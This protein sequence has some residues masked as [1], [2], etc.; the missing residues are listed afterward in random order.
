MQG[1]IAGDTHVAAN[2]RAD[3]SK[4]IK[5]SAMRNGFDR[6]TYVCGQC[7]GLACNGRGKSIKQTDVFDEWDAPFV[8]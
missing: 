8:V 7:I 5:V 6:E 3:R 1:E 4:T 2:Y